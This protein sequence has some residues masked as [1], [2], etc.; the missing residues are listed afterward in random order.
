MWGRDVDPE[1]RDLV[2][3][4]EAFLSGRYVEFLLDREDYVPPWAWT[5]LL[6]HGSV[7]QLRSP[8][9]S[10]AVNWAD[11]LEPW[12]K[13]RAYLAGEVLETA[14]RYGPV[15]RVQRRALIPLELKLAS[16]SR[17]VVVGPSEWVTM[18]LG[19]LTPLTIWKSTRPK[20]A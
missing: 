4:C 5:N 12:L 7:E 3:E 9:T 16:R 19:A 11:V 8:G 10:F 13:A 14:H 6:A 18:V 17:P 1:E 2:R 15:L 20:A